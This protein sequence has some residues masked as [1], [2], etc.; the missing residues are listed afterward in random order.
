MHFIF[1]HEYLNPTSDRDFNSRGCS[2][3]YTAVFYTWDNEAK[4]EMICINAQPFAV[5]RNVWSCLLALP[6]K[7]GLIWIDTIC[8]NQSNAIERS[9]QVRNMSEIY[10]LAWIVSVSLGE[11]PSTSVIN[12]LAQAPISITLDAAR[13]IPCLIVR[14]ANHRYWTRMW[15]IQEILLAGIVEFYFRWDQYRR[16]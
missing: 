15:I 16:G 9:R 2:P 7:W 14:L 10:R 6:S 3:H 13:R 5:T 4:T 1:I 11:A 8:I 12:E